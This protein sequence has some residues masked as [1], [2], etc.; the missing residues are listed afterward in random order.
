[1]PSTL[2]FIHTAPV[3]IP[4]FTQL[5]AERDPA[6]PVQHIVD[7]ALLR[8]A[9]AEG[10]TPA[11]NARVAATVRDAAEAG[12]AVIVC[13]CSTL[14]GCAEDAQPHVSA[15]VFRIDR[16]MAERAVALGSR[17]V[18][19]AALESTIA[20]TCTLLL[21]A[22]RRHGATPALIEVVCD[23]AWAHFEAGDHAGYL[24]A[25]ADCLR[26][27]AVRGDVLVLAQA[28]MAGAADMCADL[29]V[30][31]LSSPRLGVETAIQAYYSRGQGL[32]VTV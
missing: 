32:G 4:T 25:V 8:D 7:E 6:I 15:P 9:R 28:S 1:M 21:D 5:V 19:V 26:M 20:P 24:R 16:P 12:A 23:G 31:I 27:A 10:I 22:A 14:G 30:P 17:I 18:V 2:T 13:T 29:H 3:H 11:I